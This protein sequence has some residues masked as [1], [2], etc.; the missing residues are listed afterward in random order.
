MSTYTRDNFAQTAA[1]SVTTELS[2]NPLLSLFTEHTRV[3]SSFTWALLPLFTTCISRYVRMCVR[4]SWT[5]KN[6]CQSTVSWIV[7]LSLPTSWIN[8][9]DGLS[10]WCGIFVYLDGI[11]NVFYLF[12]FLEIFILIIIV[13]SKKCEI[14]KNLIMWFSIYTY[15][16]E[17]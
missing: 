9:V 5:W 6:I 8:T 15:E 2:H 7:L 12:S 1:H 14:S 16:M 3:K 10:C 17:Y 4:E 11:W 13:F